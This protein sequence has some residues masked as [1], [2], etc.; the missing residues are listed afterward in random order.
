VAGGG[1]GGQGCS[2]HGLVSVWLM[3]ALQISSCDE[4]IP[5]CVGGKRIERVWVPPPHGTEHS[6]HAGHSGAKIPVCE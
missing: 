4:Y 3:L 1:G 5:S 2:L 6:L